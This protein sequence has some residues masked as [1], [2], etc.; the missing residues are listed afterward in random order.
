L[1]P[2]ELSSRI[3][4]VSIVHNGHETQIESLVIAMIELD[5]NKFDKILTSLLIKEGFENTIFNV[6]YPFFDRIGVLWQTGTINPAQE[7]FISNLV[8]QKVYVAIDGIQAEFKQGAKTFLLFLPEWEQHEL[9]MLIY[10]YMIKSRGHKV[11]YLGQN[12]PYEDL[13]VVMGAHKPDYLF[14]SFSFAVEIDKLNSYV[15]N[16]VKDFPEQKILITGF[17]T[18][19]MESVP[20]NVARVESVLNFRDDLLPTI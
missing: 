16:L 13:D 2:E 10:N 14:T 18:A 15:N 20:K 3:Q 17:Q 5:E 12:V 1:D 19:E 7:H 4:E 6:I 11:I 9:G 8:K